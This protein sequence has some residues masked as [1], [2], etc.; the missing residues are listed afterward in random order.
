MRS[1]N[2][3]CCRFSNQPAGHRH[4]GGLA[5]ATSGA[6]LPRPQNLDHDPLLS[7]PTFGQLLLSRLH[8]A[9]RFGLH[10]LGAD[11]SL[12]LHVVLP[13][14]ERMEAM[15]QCH[16]LPPGSGHGAGKR[17]RDARRD[18]TTIA[19]LERPGAPSARAARNTAFPPVP[20]F[21]AHGSALL[22]SGHS[23]GNTVM[24]H[25]QYGKLLVSRMAADGVKT[26]GRC[27]SSPGRF[28]EATRSG[29]RGRAGCRPS[30][31][32]LRSGAGAAKRGKD[33]SE[34]RSCV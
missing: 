7:S 2:V 25:G 34:S 1:P 11:G 24:D 20:R 29:S 26:P 33:P 8:P 32:R 15:R 17:P 21:A 14:D 19:T 18:P 27:C 10:Q 30:R 5:G 31:S 9:F 3:R 6:M 28:A 22:P 12:L 16:L 13:R 23:Q 4:K